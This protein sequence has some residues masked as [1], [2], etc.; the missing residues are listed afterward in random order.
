MI[1]VGPES[2]WLRRRKI[3]FAELVDVPWI[4][5][6]LEIVRGAPLFEAFSGL[7]FP[8]AVIFSNSLSLRT[9]LLADGRFVTLVPGSVLQFGST[10]LQ[11][12]PLPVTLPRSLVPVVI[13]T[14]ILL[15][16]ASQQL[17]LN[18]EMRCPLTC[19]Q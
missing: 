1:V 8:R 15:R 16:C 19:R 14:L 3:A 2:K 17:A 18:D 6:R 7:S 9:K 5:T 11:F 12:M 10:H 4:L 13:T